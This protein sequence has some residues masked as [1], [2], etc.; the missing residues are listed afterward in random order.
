MA[1]EAA[2]Q[3]TSDERLTATAH[4]LGNLNTVAGPAS[5][6]RYLPSRPIPFCKLV[7]IWHHWASTGAFAWKESL[8]R[9][10][11]LTLTETIEYLGSLS[12]IVVFMVLIFCQ[13]YAGW[14]DIRRGELAFFIADVFLPPFGALRG[15]ALFFGLI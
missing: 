5:A 13:I 10:V 1:A 11:R 6:S 3:A 8:L 15:F 14:R 7:A 4:I 9:R 2:T 12:I